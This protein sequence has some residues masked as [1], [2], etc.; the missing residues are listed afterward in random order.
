MPVSREEFAKYGLRRVGAEEGVEERGFLVTRAMFCIRLSI[1][2]DVYGYHVYYLHLPIGSEMCPTG[3]R[4]GP[5]VEGC[6]M[7]NVYMPN[8][9]MV[10]A[11][12]LTL[13]T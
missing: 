11:R 5:S 9:A 1:K 13:S 2:S 10:C 7:K 8:S 3:C 12:G 4:D 6:D